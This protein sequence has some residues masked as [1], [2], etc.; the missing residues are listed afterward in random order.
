MQ[1]NWKGTTVDVYHDSKKGVVKKE[2]GDWLC[3]LY[4]TNIINKEEIPYNAQLIAD[5]FNVRKQIDCD[6]PEL[7][8]Q[9]N[10]MLEMLKRVVS[11]K[12]NINLFEIERLIKKLTK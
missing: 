7:L 5:A 12:A 8:E 9:R 1:N 11:N 2:N 10:E 4:Y 6:L 3:Q